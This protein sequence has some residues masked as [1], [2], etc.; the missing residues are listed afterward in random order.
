MSFLKKVDKT[1]FYISAIICLIFVAWTIALPESANKVF[2]AALNFFTS[3]FGWSYFICVSLF[4]LFCIFIA[5]SKFGKIRLGKDDDKPDYSTS[6]WF[7]MLFSA[8]M[9]IGLVFW[10][11][12]EPM[13][14][15]AGPPIGD[16]STM[17]S[18]RLAM[19]YAY[20]HWGLH[21]WGCYALVGMSLA[22]FQ[23]RK[24]L[25]ALVS[26]T[27]YPVLG[28]KGINGP[29]GRAI[30]VLAVF[31]TI[32]G[33]ATSL[34]LGAMQINGGFSHL[35]GIPNTTSVT[36]IIIAI[37]TV[38]FT[39][40]AVTGIDKGIQILSNINMSLA[41]I[42][43][44]FLLIAGP[45][46]WLLNFFTD[47]IGSYFQ[48]IIWMSFYTDPMGA[49]ERNAG[50]D[51]IGAWT[52]FYWAWWVAWGPFVGGFIARISKGRTVREFVLGVLIAPTLISF[53]W[54]AVFGGCAIHIDLFGAGG[55]GEAVSENITSAM[56]VTLQQFPM[57]GF[58]AFLATLMISTFFITSADSATFVVGML[59]SGG[60]LEPD[61]SLKV[62]WGVLEGAI[63]AVLL[64]AGGL[65]ALQTASIAAAFPFMII[66]I[67]MMFSIYKAFKGEFSLEN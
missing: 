37:V 59:T 56:F 33:V 23:F 18:A 40:S 35:Y 48:N 53:L 45:T 47:T 61:A 58:F 50:Y 3:N 7:A 60:N 43:I 57:G 9:G 55:I 15:F 63:A 64:M 19:R 54:F 25:P 51:W 44:L 13:M 46:V 31:A 4:L 38:L 14:H 65:G 5:F 20:F 2:N 32:F 52:V 22:Y 8:G 24:G 34:G 41:A 39:I 11:I 30:D 26:S 36:V 49:Y 27:F 1:I 28:Q 29:I 42:L 12:A 10:S 21:P 62:F 16:G 6:S 66:M 17:E 67:F